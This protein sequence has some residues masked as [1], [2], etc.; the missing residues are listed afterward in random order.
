MFFLVSNLL[1]LYIG[2]SLFIYY[3]GLNPT[4]RGNE[5]PKKGRRKRGRII[6][7]CF[8]SCF[9]RHHHHLRDS[10]F[11]NRF[12]QRLLAKALLC[13][14]NDFA[15]MVIEMLARLVVL[16]LKSGHIAV[17]NLHLLGTPRKHFHSALLNSPAQILEYIRGAACVIMKYDSWPDIPIQPP[18]ERR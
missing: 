14:R 5:R 13:L 3:Q 2:S 18:R 15:R 12:I 16:V 4:R 6:H 10:T 9:Y 11:L 7:R 1:L 17:G 8:L